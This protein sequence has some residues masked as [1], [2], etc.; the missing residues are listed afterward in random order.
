M[1]VSGGGGGGGGG[2]GELGCTYRVATVDEHLCFF[3]RPLFPLFLLDDEAVLFVVRDPA[4]LTLAFGHGVGYAG[5][6][7]KCP[8][9]YE[10]WRL[11]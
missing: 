3:F 7:A 6:V 8:S 1:S 4:N 11:R 9:G 10:T 5:V 2:G